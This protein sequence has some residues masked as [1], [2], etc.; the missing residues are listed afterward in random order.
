MLNALID[1]IVF[2]NTHQKGIQRY[3]REVITRIAIKETVGVSLLMENRSAVSLPSGATI[4][5][6]TDWGWHANE[7]I[8]KR[9][10]KKLRRNISPGRI[11]IS[12]LF[13]STYY[14]H[15]PDPV[16][17]TV[18]T[19]YDMIPEAMPHFFASDADAE[20]NKKK[21]CILN[22][23]AIITISESTKADLIRV[24]PEVRDK[25]TSIPLGADH[26][27][28]EKDAFRETNS[29]SEI[30]YVLFVGDRLG[31]KNFA[32]LVEALCLRQW[33]SEVRLVV[34]GKPFSDAEATW[35]RYRGVSERIIHLGTVSDEQLK[36][37]YLT[38]KVFVFPSLME[39]FG[40]PIL[41]AQSLGTPVVASDIP[42]FKEVGGSAFEPCNSMD[43]SS[44][45]DA[46]NRVLN[47]PAN[48]QR[49]NMGRANVER[50]K[51]D[52]CAKETLKVW[53]SCH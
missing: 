26:L 51:W 44:L 23:Q 7:G 3:W 20:I 16:L 31:Y 35:L 15:S 53:Q 17:P 14:T 25:I 48:V 34:V 22:A 21:N 9:L 32:T 38:A 27:H 5:D 24:Y 10:V 28:E 40:L 47:D 29:E 52:T 19:V 11:P 39:G 4:V 49:K 6:R 2:Q 37:I 45:A 8:M 30:P 41:E 46:I 12:N 33:D 1:G 36:A 43:P 42:A 18:L 13:H 50:F